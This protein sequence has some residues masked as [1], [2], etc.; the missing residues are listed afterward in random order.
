VPGRTETAQRVAATLDGRGSVIVSG[1]AGIGKTT[2]VESVLRGRPHARGT[3]VAGLRW[4]PYLPLMRAADQHLDGDAE[5]VAST[6][7]VAIGGRVLFV[8]DLHW[9]DAATI[10]VLELL[11]DRVPVVMTC[12]PK[13]APQWSDQVEIIEVG[14]LSRSD[15]RRLARRLHP[16][17]DRDDLDRLLAA[18]AGNPLLL[19]N[20]ARD[21]TTTPTLR[22]AMATRLHDL[23]GPV[24]DAIA[25][26]ATHGLP[27]DLALLD[28]TADELP[29]GLVE[30]Q[31]GQARLRHLLL[32]DAALESLNAAE[33]A[34]V[35]L[36][37]AARLPG[38]TP[39]S[40]SWPVGH[41]WTP[42]GACASCSTTSTTR[43]CAPTS[44]RSR[45]TP[46]TTT[47]SATRPPAPWSRP[48]TAKGHVGRPR[49]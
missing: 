30:V 36:R 1:A 7:S 40:T 34:E 2:L 29:A 19:E 42:N 21:G 39:P 23:S 5:T 31:G 49:R 44:W 11:I 14:P 6:I 33:R 10:D 25:E 13:S 4:R 45:P 22:A 16:E 9:A 12:R 48:A 26:L 15:A 43:C 28:V 41:R 37:L 35:H 27:L 24:R 38:P 3:A 17:L 20:L 18:A 8:D 32:G 46:P 47:T